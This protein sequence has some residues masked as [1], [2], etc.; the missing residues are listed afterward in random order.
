MKEINAMTRDALRALI[1]DDEK[2]IQRLIATSLRPRGFQCDLASDGLQAVAQIENI[3]YDVVITDLRMPNMHGHALVQRLLDM[4]S[5]PA[6][7]VHTGVL[8]PKLAGDL[9]ERGVDDIVYKPVD[10]AFLAIKVASHVE[11]RCGD[12]ARAADPP[13][14]NERGPASDRREGTSFQRFNNK[15]A[16]VERLLPLSNAAIKVY[17]MTQ[18]GDWHAGAIA[19]AIQ[20]DASLTADVLRLAN[21]G[22][23]GPTLQKVIRLEDAVQRIGHRKLGEIALVSSALSAMTKC[24]LP[25]L[26]ANLCWQ[27]S[28]A[29]GIVL[30]ALAECSNFEDASNAAFLNAIMHPLG[31]VLLGS[32][33]PELYAEMIAACRSDGSAISEQERCL[34]PVNDAEA[35]VHCL[36]LWNVSEKLLLPLK[37]SSYDFPSLRRLPEPLR[38]EAELVKTAVTL[39]NIVVGRW[40]DWD[41]VETPPVEV[42]ERLGVADLRGM[43]L[44][45]RSDLAQIASFHPSGAPIADPAE[46]A[47]ASIPYCSLSTPPIDPVQELLPTLGYRLENCGENDLLDARRAIIV[48]C[49]NAWPGRFT[50]LKRSESLLLIT[51]ESHREEFGRMGRTISLPSSVAQLH[52]AIKALGR[53]SE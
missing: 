1:V 39:G 8:E 15:L 42:L 48:N 37:F 38:F 11:K 13:A 27:R 4:P 46:G 43:L 40:H 45:A 26:N 44:Q 53:T 10:F 14:P 49:M 32:M 17:E 33:F 28:M 19:A 6:I 21:C 12:A 25:W 41:L 20:R 29:A 5:R 30:E 52:N 3:P 31:R 9:L 34:L 47:S 50:T 22:L 36:A 35:L 51:R 2:D 24:A 23:F 7:V 16:A 18:D